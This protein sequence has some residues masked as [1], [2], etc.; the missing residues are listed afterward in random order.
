MILSKRRIHTTSCK[1][2]FSLRKP[3]SKTI[4][5]HNDCNHQH[6]HSHHKHSPLLVQPDY[7]VRTRFAPSPTGF[8]HLGSLR[9]ALYNYLLAKSTGGQ[10]LLRLEDTDQNRL[11][12]GAEENIYQTLD[13]LKVQIDEGPIHPG[14]YSPYRQSERS[15]IY[16]KYIQKLLDKGLAYRCFCSKERLD[17]LRDSARLLKPPTTVSY[18]RFCL[19]NI[20]EDESLK[21]ALDGE[22][23]TVRFK[24]PDVYPEFEDLLHGIINLQPQI[25]PD[26]RRYEDPVLMK[27]DNLPTYHFA[28]V[29]DDHLMKIT[30]VIRG[31]EWIASTPKHIA[32]YNA[33]GWDKPKFIHIPLLTTVEG[34]KLS[35]RSGD[36]DIMSLKKKG[37]LNE[38]LVNFSILFGWNPKRELGEKSSEIFSIEDLAK[39]WNLNGLTKGNAKVDWKKLD[40]FNKHYLT[41]K[42]SDFDGDFFK[43]AVV[44]SHKNISKTLNLPEL[45][46]QKVERVLK[47]VYPSLI[48]L[49]DFDSEMYHY[50]FIQPSLTK[51]EAISKLKIKEET[52]AQ[53]A[54]ELQDR[55]DA[56]TH[57]EFDNTIN[58]IMQDIPQLK[59]KAIFQTLRYALSGPQSGINLPVII[60]LLGPNEVKSRI[61]KFNTL[62]H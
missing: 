10:F 17:G 53:I 21:R 62:F 40:Y 18:D 33:F 27:S 9:T 11:V 46:I 13:W 3:T 57:F 7:P 47:M 29:V 44:E 60:E 36:I 1:L 37:Y 4:N 15:S 31:E 41:E 43:N 2:A 58:K 16:Q 8:L 45:P 12:E 34:K 6:E 28:N 50:F 38:A 24:A 23:F 61:S 26:D 19:H 51:D 30:H 5:T 55:A 49:N 48:K 35:K 39:T 56:L 20:S 32:L 54:K 22:Q 14:P 42:M 59:K 25:N 52:L